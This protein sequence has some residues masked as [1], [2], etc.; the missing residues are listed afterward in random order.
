MNH[1][2]R[3]MKVLTCAVIYI[4]FLGVF[5]NAQ[6]IAQVKA[7][8]QW[9]NFN[10][11]TLGSLNDYVENPN[12]LEFSKYGGWKAHQ[13]DA[14]GFFR[15]E[16]INDR[17]WVIDPEGYLY[18]HKALNS[19]NLNN[20]TPDEIYQF[21][22]K[23][24]FN[25]MGCWSN[26]NILASSLKETTP[27][28]YCPKISF[29]AQY[30]RRRNPRI[31]MPVFDDEFETFAKS[32]ADYFLPYK[33]DPQVFG[34]FSDN[35]LSWR[36]DGLPAHLAITD[37]T[38]KNY[39]TAVDFLQSR[40]KTPDNWTKDDQYEYMTVM[41]E[42]YYSI[43]SKAI[44]AVDPNHMYIGTRCHSTER[45]I[46][47]FMINAG[48][49]VDVFS[50]NRYNR[51]G[52]RKVEL[53]NM[54]KWS[55]R[56]MIISEF[57]AM[58]EIPDNTG[59]GWVVKRQAD[60]GPFYQNFVSTFLENGN[61][62]GFHWFKFEDEPNAVSN[63]GVVNNNGEPYTELLTY[64]QEL[65]ERIYD[66]IDYVDS[67]ETPDYVLYPE[68]DAYYK[69]TTNFGTDPELLVKLASSAK[70]TRDIYIRFDISSIHPPVESAKIRLNAVLESSESGQYQAELVSDNTWTENGI[71][72]ENSP[73]GST[74]LA[75]WGSGDDV[76]IDVTDELRNAL[77]KD[78]KLS[79]RIISTLNNGNI[80]GYGSREHSNP[81]A[82]PKLFV[83]G[84][85]ETN[86]ELRKKETFAL[87]IYPNPCSDI[88][89]ISTLFEKVE[90]MDIT[91]KHI[92]TIH[93]PVNS[94]DVSGLKQGSYIL[95]A[96][97]NGNVYNRNIIKF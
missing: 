77:S 76:E 26:E 60:R 87:H 94:I 47:N 91:G 23:Y 90:I 83:V 56:P 42:R 29:I 44:K 31:E 21:L 97:N 18:I 45:F 96:T 52:E 88:V 22:D 78:K 84:N 1:P 27:M 50:S 14:T 34:Y 24:G 10:C 81:N 62:V 8:G 12:N 43:V 69:N 48:K 82:R 80:P 33:D 61:V 54:A 37:H 7:T 51:W 59:A 13:A 2:M 41:A 30:R 74:V 20:H 63:K 64:M 65:N 9:L 19:I 6:E 71:N 58:E 28:A 89:K 3:N 49:Y 92:R 38:D 66:Y 85:P 75:T 68:A 72:I 25:G 39:I 35:E 79:V 36:D 11:Q 32:A 17:W 4:V 55:G 15:V 95:R 16:K 73:A 46:E 86:V 40:G 70:F 67:R 53:D 5:I 93:S 57:Y